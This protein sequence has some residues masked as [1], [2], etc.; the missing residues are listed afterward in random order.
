[1]YRHLRFIAPL[2]LFVACGKH[3]PEST[4]M[5]SHGMPAEVLLVGAAA[6]EAWLKPLLDSG[7][8]GPQA[9]LSP[10]EP[11]YRCSFIH[12]EEAQG[13]A[14]GAALIIL[15][16]NRQAENRKLNTLWEEA[17]Q[18][19]DRKSGILVAGDVWAKGQ[20]VLLLEAS[21]ENQVRELASAGGRLADVLFESE[22]AI[23]LY[24][25]LLPNK[26][27][28][29]VMN[30]VAGDFGFS[31]PLPPQFRLVQ[32]NKEMLWFIWEGRDFRANLWV[33]ILPETMSNVSVDRMIQLRDTFA[34]RYIRGNQGLNMTSSRSTE[35]P[36]FESPLNKIPGWRG[37]WTISGQWQ[38]GPYRRFLMNDPAG[39]RCIW[40]EGF[41]E[42]PEIANNPYY[43]MFDLIAAGFNFTNNNSV[44][45]P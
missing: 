9:G 24:G 8:G 37:W 26:Y 22:C 19:A 42:A 32:S 33:N 5:V 1:M 14:L 45:R 3:K 38:R 10:A 6:T 44:A 4:S 25:G 35:Y 41:L 16:K 12:P 34:A 43:R 40:L 13:D 11:R 20:K 15:V 27:S 23:G 39:Q 21:S 7:I 17:N 2:L 18:K 28:D 29:S 30:R 36:S 31:F